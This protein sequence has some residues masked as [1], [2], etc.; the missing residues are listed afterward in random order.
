MKFRKNR[1][2]KYF[3]YL[4]YILVLFLIIGCRENERK[5]EL[6]F[7]SNVERSHFRDLYFG[8]LEQFS[9]ST[10]RIELR[11][12][13]QKVETDYK[14]ELACKALSSSTELQIENGILDDSVFCIVNQFIKVNSNKFPQH[15]WI[16]LQLYRGVHFTQK[17]DVKRAIK[18]LNKLVKLNPDSY[19]SAVSLSQVYQMLARIYSF[20]G[21]QQIAISYCEK[22]NSYLNRIN[23]REE[24]QSYFSTL[25]YLYTNVDDF[26]KAE[27][28]MNKSIYY[29]RKNKDTFSLY[30]SLLQRVNIYQRAKNLNYFKEIK[31]LHK[32]ISRREIHYPLIKVLDALNTSQV[33]LIK[34]HP[35]EAKKTLTS[36]SSILDRYN[37]VLEKEMYSN[38]WLYC[39]IEQK[40]PLSNKK[41]LEKKLQLLKNKHDYITNRNIYYM[42]KQDAINQNNFKQALFYSE[43]MEDN[44]NLLATREMKIKFAEIETKYNI[45]KKTQ[46]LL[47]QKFQLKRKNNFIFILV[48]S[49][50]VTFLG[51]IGYYLYQ[52]QRKLKNETTQKELFT[53]LLIQHT[54]DERKRIAN[55]LHDVIGHELL[56][57]KHMLGTEFNALSEKV[58]L[59]INDLRGIS[60]NLHPIMFEKLGLKVV[61]EQL[62]ERLQQHEQLLFI[63]DINYNGSLD[64]KTELQLYRIIQES[65]SNCIKH[66]QTHA[67]K[68]SIQEVGSQLIIE[69]MDSGTGFDV[70]EKMASNSTFGLLSILERSHSIKG[71]PSI[72]SSQKGTIIRIKLNLL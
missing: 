21:K 35:F 70:Q 28:A 71:I 2:M 5:S 43:K 63:C 72:T 17:S 42:L 46:Q 56:T 30:K 37:F 48:L 22:A 24:R 34:R 61:V 57:F 27:D 53:N 38:L 69:I 68:I 13:T 6:F 8:S 31:R 4:V 67:V 10:Y 15:Y 25:S 32:I 1:F 54:E 44:M 45:H 19:E 65:L 20:T 59:L 36:I 40:I 26:K 33:L 51:V 55:D 58:D 9:S 49:L 62:I 29:A 7:K 52:K 18:C 39:D 66:S 14:F 12:K 16:K 64:S 41:E 11:N 50:M 23:A 3:N 60:R 47:V